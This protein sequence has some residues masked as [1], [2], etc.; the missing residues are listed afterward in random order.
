MVDELSM[1][2]K[3]SDYWGYDSGWKWHELQA[4]LPASDL[5]MLASKVLSLDVEQADTM[6]WLDVNGCRFNVKSAY[7][8]ACSWPEEVTWR[9]WKRIWSLKTAQRVR[10]FAWI[11]MHGKLL[12]NLERWRRKITDNPNCTRCSGG[13]ED[14]LH[15]IGDYKWASE[16]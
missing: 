15:V 8:L 12:T 2:K 7:R 10:V 1:G 11:L 3:V 6:G 5:I 16:V 13:R 14:I 4:M 9:D